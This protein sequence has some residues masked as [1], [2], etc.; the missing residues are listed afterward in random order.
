MDY[1]YIYRLYMVYMCIMD[2]F[3]FPMITKVVPQT[4]IQLYKRQ[5]GQV[6]RN[7]QGYPTEQKC[8]TL[9]NKRLTGID[10]RASN[11]SATKS[12]MITTKT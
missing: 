2:W 10:H 5:R 1:I 12:I 3:G 7:T 9:N 8:T 6:Q 11:E 4:R